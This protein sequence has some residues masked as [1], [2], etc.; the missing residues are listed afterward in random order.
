MG[1][2]EILRRIWLFSANKIKRSESYSEQPTQHIVELKSSLR[3]IIVTLGNLKFQLWLWIFPKDKFSF[4]IQNDVN[5]HVVLILKRSEICKIVKNLFD[6]LRN[7]IFCFKT[8]FWSIRNSG[9]VIL[10]IVFKK[11]HSDWFKDYPDQTKFQVR[12]H[13]HFIALI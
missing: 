10:S 3:H 9:L 2:T 5:Y 7:M 13:S 4:Q 1:I 6:K 12:C 11:A 8:V